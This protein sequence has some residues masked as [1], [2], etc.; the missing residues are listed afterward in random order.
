MK[1]MIPLLALALVACDD[2]PKQTESA[3]Q[4][5]SD[6]PLLKLQNDTVRKVETDIGAAT[7]KMREALNNID[8]Q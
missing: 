6:N 3:L 4:A 7:D 2:T 1:Y 5:G 8:K